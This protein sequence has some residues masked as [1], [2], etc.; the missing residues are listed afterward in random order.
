MLKRQLAFTVQEAL[1][2]LPK[3]IRNPRIQ[4]WVAQWSGMVQPLWISS[5][6]RVLKLDHH[7]LEVLIPVNFLTCAVGRRGELEESFLMLAANQGL[8]FFLHQ[9]NDKIHYQGLGD[10]RLEILES[11]IKGP[12]RFKM[13]L[14]EEQREALVVPN[15]QDLNQES[16]LELFGQYFSQD[17]KLVAIGYWTAKVKRVGQIKQV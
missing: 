13:Q 11:P 1:K 15:F 7:Q 9:L 17:H 2:E 16:S 10:F 4:K 3:S 14:S 6:I 12:I 8:K 5:R